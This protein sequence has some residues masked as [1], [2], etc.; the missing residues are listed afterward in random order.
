MRTTDSTAVLL[1]SA[2]VSSPTSDLNVPARQSKIWQDLPPGLARLPDGRPFAPHHGL[3]PPHVAYGSVDHARH[4]GSLQEFFQHAHQLA[5]ERRPPTPPTYDDDTHALPLRCP[6][7]NSRHMHRL[8]PNQQQSMQSSHVSQ[9]LR[10]SFRDLL[11][12]TREYLASG[13]NIVYTNHLTM[14]NTDGTGSNRDDRVVHAHSHQTDQTLSAACDR[15]PALGLS[16]QL[17]HAPAHGSPYVALPTTHYAPPSE[18]D[19]SWRASSIASSPTVMDRHG[20][21]C[22]TPVVQQWRTDN[23]AARAPVRIAKKKLDASSRRKQE[24]Y[25]QKGEA[26]RHTIAAGMSG[27]QAPVHIPLPTPGPP[28]AK[29]TASRKRRKVVPTTNATLYEDVQN[30]RSRSASTTHFDVHIASVSGAVSPRLEAL[31][32]DEAIVER[33]AP[34]LDEVPQPIVDK[35]EDYKWPV[36]LYELQPCRGYDFAERWLEQLFETGLQSEYQRRRFSHVSKGFI[37]DGGR[38][39]LLV[40]HNATNPFEYEPAP[41]STVTMGVYGYHWYRHDEIHWTTLGSDQR[42]LLEQCVEME[43]L[44]LKHKWSAGTDKAAEK[45]FHRAYWLA[46]NRQDLKGLLNRC[47]SHDKPEDVVEEKSAEDP[48]AE[49]GISEADLTNAWDEVSEEASAA[50]WL[51]VQ[52]EVEALDDAWAVHGSGWQHVVTG[53]SEW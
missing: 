15:P 49:F 48:D 8:L 2:S 37:K 30:L 44:L 53:S 9:G 35:Y 26:R 41:D 34:T 21:L 20:Q 24:I 38:H 7:S 42:Q 27:L 16:S 3:N 4:T 23:L 31:D 11:P 51:G 10:P 5:A 25:R 22:Q 18:H 43:C 36:C 39:S 46:A 29:A 14:W 1:A 52:E 50:A 40:L 45:R 12:H 13:P 47:P 28:R 19:Y 33:A 32:Y 6:D 17:D